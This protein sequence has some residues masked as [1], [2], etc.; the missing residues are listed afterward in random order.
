LN[1]VDEQERAVI[2][3][4]SE[5]IGAAGDDIEVTRNVR[6]EL[7]QTKRV[8]IETCIGGKLHVT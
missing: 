4:Q 5:R 8:P 2:R 1:A 7:D 3:I 6:A